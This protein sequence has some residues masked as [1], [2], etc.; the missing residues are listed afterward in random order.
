MSKSKCP[1]QDTRFWRPGDVF[2]VTCGQCGNSVE[3]FKDDAT[4]R[5]PKCGGRIRNPKFSLGCA[6]WC[7]QAKECLGFDPKELKEEDTEEISLVD[8]LIEAMKREFGD[9]QK[10]ITHALRVLEHAQE[11]K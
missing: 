4:R 6:Q 7:E 3:F 8:K 2:D 1:G 11:R 9:D 10:R 5:C